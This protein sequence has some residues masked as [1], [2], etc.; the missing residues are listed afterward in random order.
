MSKLKAESVSFSFVFVFLFFTISNVGCFV[1]FCFVS[2]WR[3]SVLLDLYCPE[4]RPDG[5]APALARP[6]CPGGL[7]CSPEA[8]V[9]PG[10]SSTPHSP[11]VLAGRLLAHCLV[12]V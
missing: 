10:P 12:L 11:T 4:K 2:W 6:L 7:F 3:F 5:S 9:A 1:L 8:G